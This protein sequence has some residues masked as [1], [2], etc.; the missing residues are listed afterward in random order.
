MPDDLRKE[1]EDFLRYCGEIARRIGRGGFTDIPHLVSLYEQLKRALES[2]S[3][4]ELAWA[5]EQARR[6]VE[7]L[8]AMNAKLSAV[9]RFKATIEQDTGTDDDGPDVPR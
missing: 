8:V 6:L 7:K 3:A 9:R 2:V 5:D 1:S 4:K